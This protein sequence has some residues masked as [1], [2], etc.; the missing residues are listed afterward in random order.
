MSLRWYGD[1]EQERVLRAT[2]VGINRT[3]AVCVREAKPLTPYVTG[4]LRRSIRI[5]AKAVTYAW[6]T[7][8]VWGS[9][10]CVYAKFIEF[11]TYKM[12]ERPFLR[13]AAERVY[14]YLPRFI[15]EAYGA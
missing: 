5:F 8:G 4:T 12:R 11:G 13:P 2:R 15:R 14:P 6:G 9:V 1:R 10:A 7:Y 3:M